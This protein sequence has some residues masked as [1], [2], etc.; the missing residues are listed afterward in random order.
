MALRRIDVCIFWDRHKRVLQRTRRIKH[1]I[2]PIFVS[3]LVIDYAWSCDCT[4]MGAIFCTRVAYVIRG[5]KK[6]CRIHII[7]TWSTLGRLSPRALS[8]PPNELGTIVSLLFLLFLYDFNLSRVLY[9]GHRQ[10]QWFFSYDDRNLCE[11]PLIYI[12]VYTNNIHR[13]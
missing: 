12:F 5:K 11:F 8:P 7:Y 1:T 3:Y 9:S 4:R 10:A 13:G 6:C 2:C